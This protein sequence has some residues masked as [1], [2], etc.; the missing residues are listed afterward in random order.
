MKESPLAHRDQNPL[1]G[2]DPDDL[3]DEDDFDD[4]AGRTLETSLVQKLL[5]PLY[6]VLLVVFI[7]ISIVPFLILYTV[8]WMIWDVSTNY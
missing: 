6:L 7:G 1:D 3:D 8:G 2:R 4:E 5:S